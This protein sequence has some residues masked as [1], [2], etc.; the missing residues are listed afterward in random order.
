MNASQ[1]SYLS[2]IINIFK[3]FCDKTNIKLHQ[4]ILLNYSSIM[5]DEEICNNEYLFQKYLEFQLRTRM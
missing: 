5:N 3:Q 4:F 1:I 2:R